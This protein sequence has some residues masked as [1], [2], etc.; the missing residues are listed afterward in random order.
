MAD[1]KTDGEQVRLRDFAEWLD[2]AG[3]LA[4]SDGDERTYEDL[5]KEFQDE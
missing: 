3:L 2:Q 1:N 4:K 5:V